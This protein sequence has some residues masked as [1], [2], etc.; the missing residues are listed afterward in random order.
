VSYSAVAL[1]LAA[2]T[3]L[4]TVRFRVLSD[5]RGIVTDVE[6]GIHAR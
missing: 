4:R 3:C 2:R 6:G 1:L 5:P